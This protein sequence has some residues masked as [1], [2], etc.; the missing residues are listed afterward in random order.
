MPGVEQPTRR[1]GVGRPR[2]G[3]TG[4]RRTRAAGSNRP[5]PYWM[6]DGEPKLSY[7]DV[8]TSLI[9]PRPRLYG[10]VGAELIEEVWNRAATRQDRRRREQCLQRKQFTPASG[11]SGTPAVKTPAARPVPFDS[12]WPTAFRGQPHEKGISMSDTNGSHSGRTPTRPHGA[13]TCACSGK[14]DRGS[15]VIGKGTRSSSSRT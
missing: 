1:R 12:R 10:L 3:A 15:P 7:E 6:S 9:P 13:S 8:N 14:T 11:N 5:S 2:P 4:S